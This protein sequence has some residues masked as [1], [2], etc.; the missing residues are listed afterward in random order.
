MYHVSIGYQKTAMCKHEMDTKIAGLV[1][2]G[3]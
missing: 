1:V 2:R 3:N